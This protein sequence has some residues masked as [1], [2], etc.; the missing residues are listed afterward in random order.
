[1]LMN[2]LFVFLA[3]VL[4]GNAGIIEGF[5]QP[6]INPLQFLAVIAVGLISAQM[7]KRAIWMLPLTFIIMMSVG[8][9]IGFVM[10]V[11]IDSAP[12]VPY[13][14]AISLVVFGIA[15]LLQ[16]DFSVTI[17]IIVVGIFALFHGYAHGE[18]FPP[19]QQS[20]Y[21]F[22][23]IFGIIISTAGL[24]VISV[25]IGFITLRFERGTLILRIAG[26][27]IM[28]AG[29]FFLLELLQIVSL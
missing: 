16:K 9:I 1:M 26:L 18:A 5:L 21:F 24:K 12:I 2:E 10:T 20:I 27:V 22:A 25:M 8:G 15:L 11:F 19:E 6:V 17:A 3:H 29:L 23:Y 13:I 4:P 7:G 28:L 14:E